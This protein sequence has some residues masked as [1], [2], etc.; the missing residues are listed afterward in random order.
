MSR[1]P[2]QSASRK[3]RSAPSALEDRRLAESL[4]SMKTN[5][6]TSPRPRKWAGAEGGKRC[7]VLL[8]SR[9]N[10]TEPADIL[11]DNPEQESR[12]SQGDSK[13][14]ARVADAQT[15]EI[16]NPLLQGAFLAI[17]MFYSAA[18]VQDDLRA[19]RRDGLLRQH[20]RL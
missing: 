12:K 9:P 14:Q 19:G 4:R 8:A 13:N 5:F 17:V 2:S 7:S 1:K 18:V 15:S 6:D 3:C 20:K 16:L 11:F 10:A